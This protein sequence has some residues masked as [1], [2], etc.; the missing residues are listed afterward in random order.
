MFT[1]RFGP[2]PGP[3]M[4][5]RICVD[6]G[7]KHILTAPRSPTTTGKVERF[8]RTLRLEFFSKHDYRF[9]TIE[10]AQAA[11]E[12]W[13]V[14]Y[15][16][17]RPHQSIGD[18]TPAERFALRPNRPSSSSRPRTPRPHPRTRPFRVSPAGSTRPGGSTSRASA[19]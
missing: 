7:I 9:E 10:Q 17:I 3:V 4:F 18:R 11:L 14:T 12:A 8:H 15:N 1:A 16:T 13:L 2:G 5:D 6:N 19:T